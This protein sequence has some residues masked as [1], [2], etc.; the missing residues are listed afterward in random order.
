MS[1][2]HNGKKLTSAAIFVVAVFSDSVVFVTDSAADT[3]MV[4]GIKNKGVNLIMFPNLGVN[5]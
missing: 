4:K 2:A 1:C 5:Q 3:C